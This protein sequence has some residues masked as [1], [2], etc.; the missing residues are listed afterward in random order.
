MAEVIKFRIS[1]VIPAVLCD[2]PS[3]HM[4]KFLSLHS[5]YSIVSWVCVSAVILIPDF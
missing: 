4:H 3:T 2:V 5:G 1:A